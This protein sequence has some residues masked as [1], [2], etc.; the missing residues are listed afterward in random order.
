LVFAPKVGYLQLQLFMA[1]ESRGGSM[2]EERN[3]ASQRLDTL[4]AGAGLEPLN[5]EHSSRFAEY[6]SLILRWN[7]RVNLTAIRDEEGILSRHFIE[8]IAC[9]R[10]LP[11]GV[12]TLLDY[13][14]GAG[15]PG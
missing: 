4:L 6:L 12:A 13:G 10:A 2:S 11:E 1:S 14:S 9:A 8:S 7:A 5:T 3:P 15:F